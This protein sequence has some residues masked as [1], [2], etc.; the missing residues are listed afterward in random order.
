MNQK[1]EILLLEDDANFGLILKEH[2]QMQGFGVTLCV[3]GADG[4]GKFQDNSYNLCL[5]DVMMPKMDGFTFAE[6]VRQSDQNIPLIFLTAKSLTEDKIKGFG[7]GCDDYMTKPFSIEELLLRIQAILKR[8]NASDEDDNK[9]AVFN[10][11][12]FTFDYNRSVL[13]I[14]DS[15]RKLTPKEAD[16]LRLLC[17]NL[18]KTLNRNEALRKIWGNENYFSGRSMDVF[19]S[20]LRKYLKD[21][22]QIEILG[23]HGQGIRL[24]ESK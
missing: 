9:Q 13:T 24:I 7:I 14:N 6:K 11:G 21:D 22:P 4:W 5:V 23:I 19:V 16:L 15:E 20:K 3:N 2:L 1:I 12:K 10:I 17:I 18:N 8:V